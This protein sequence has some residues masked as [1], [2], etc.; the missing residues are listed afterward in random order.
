MDEST[1]TLDVSFHYEIQNMMYAC[2]DYR[3]P[4]PESAILL[5]EIVRK[6]ISE[7]ISL[8]SEVAIRNGRRLIS[9]QDVFFL[10]RRDKVK[11]KRAQRHMKIKEMAKKTSLATSSE[12][13]KTTD[14]DLLKPSA[15]R[16]MYSLEFLSSDEDDSGP[17]LDDITIGR[18]ER[19]DM[20]TK[21]MNVREYIDYAECRQTS[22]GGKNLKK[23][24][25]WLE[26][27]AITDTKIVEQTWDLLAYL[28]Y[29][30][31][32]Q[33][34]EMSLLVR[35]DMRLSTDPFSAHHLV[36]K[37]PAHL[38][39]GGVT[40]RRSKPDEEQ[41][42]SDVTLSTEL[43]E[44]ET[45]TE[46]LGSVN[47]ETQPTESTSI[48]SSSHHLPAIQPYHIREAIRRCHM[49]GG[50]LSSFTTHFM[51]MTTSRVTVCL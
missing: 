20:M 29:D 1:E 9:V 46:R 14:T 44:K 48:E 43:A 21:T 3:L 4:S 38:D 34:V 5:E 25:E 45:I 16:K 30:T 41:A 49:P 51:P 31:L 19:N 8:A 22:F 13:D 11:M 42:V 6:Q 32:Q 27:D 35:K 47:V 26:S 40:S 39:T 36:V 15:V 17:E 18:L 37:T 33:V 23:F 2:G 28:A 12:E 24:K 7:V 10:L 50:P